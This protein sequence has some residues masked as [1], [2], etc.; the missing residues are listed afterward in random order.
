MPR[1][2]H[3]HLREA[4]QFDLFS[5]PHALR[6]ATMPSWPQLPE[7]V[8]AGATRLIVRLLLEHASSDLRSGSIGGRDDV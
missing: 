6:L 4:L 8:R 3:R 1:L 2:R 7:A 5:P